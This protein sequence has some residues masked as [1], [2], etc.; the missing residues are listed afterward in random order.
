MGI[1]DLFRPKYRH[2]DVRVRTEAVRALT[3]DDAAILIQIARTDRDIGVRR[4]AIER[5]DTADVLAELASAETERSLRDFA[6]ERAARLWTSVACGEDPDAANNALG[7]IAKLGDQ[8][9][10]VDVAVKASSAAVRKR[11]FGELRDPRA[12]AELAKR[13]ASQ[14]IRLAA[15]GRI[16]DGDV[17]RALAIDT[18]AKEVGL[19]AVEKL[20]DKD[21]LENVAQ[22]AKNK[23][24][25]Q[26]ARKIV[27]E[28][29]QAEAPKK[30]IVPDEIKRRRAEKAQLVRE[31]EAVVDTFDFDK[32][33]PR[34]R[35]LEEAWGKLPPGDE[36]DDRFGKAAER[37]WK[38]KDVHEQTYGPRV[39]ATVAAVTT[40][41][42]P[43]PAPSAMTEP[44]PVEESDAQRK[45]RD[46][47][48]E[49][50]SAE[51]EARK[52]AEAE[53]AAAVVAS[54]RAMCEDMEKVADSKH[55]RE[56]D[57]VLQQAQRVFEQIGKASASERDALSDRYTA[58][59]GKLVVRAHD[60]R[61][62]EDWA[63]FQN[64]PKAEALI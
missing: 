27:Q 2:S 9:A 64:V 32:L 11:A 3:K 22:K 23:A 56:I 19:A 4:L 41:P 43:S 38:R 49:A 42:A 8:H 30:S 45:E 36:G 46:A 1:S 53:R 47:R 40:E 10:L 39:I 61:E 51:R 16:D 44:A 59:R 35:A 14:D 60:L 28:I 34:V 33:S 52:K 6:G 12:L 20:D 55:G 50:E 29:E 63:R 57:R 7:G 48:R 58:A 37:F 15:I 13:D 18:T 21:R 17:L 26:R 24:V 5:I 62:A 54:L 31:I 25:R